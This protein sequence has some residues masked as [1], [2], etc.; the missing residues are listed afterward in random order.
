MAA[1]V[2]IENEGALFKGHSL[3]WPDEVWSHKSK[4]WEPYKGRVPKEVDWGSVIH[5]DE[6]NEIMG[7]G[8]HRMAAE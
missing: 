2:F 7:A 4:T 5:E 6:A 8:G 3:S 1:K